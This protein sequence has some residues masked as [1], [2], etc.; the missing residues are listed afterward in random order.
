[1][2]IYRGCSNIYDTQNAKA[3]FSPASVLTIISVGF[4]KYLLY[5]TQIESDS[6]STF[7]IK[8]LQQHT[9]QT[10]SV[11]NI[12]KHSISRTPTVTNVYRSTLIKHI[13]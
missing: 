11:S 10:P 4:L 1:M 12:N 2:L 9:I 3:P 6:S 13:L 8:Q 5:R 7:C